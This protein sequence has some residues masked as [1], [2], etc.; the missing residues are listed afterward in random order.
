MFAGQR[1]ETFYIDLG[2]VFDTLNLRRYLP[3]LS[4]AEDVDNVN[5][6]GN[7]RFAKTNIN[8]IAIEVPIKCLIGDDKTRGATKSDQ[9]PGDRRLCE[10]EPAEDPGAPR[11]RQ[12]RRR[13]DRCVQVARMGNPL[14][15]ELIINTPQKDKWNATDPEDEAQFQDFYK[16]PV[17]ATALELVYGVPVVPFDDSPKE[18]RTDL[19]TVLL[20]YAGQSLN[21]DRCGQPC[22]ELLRLDMSKPPTAPEKQSRLGSVLGN[23]PAGWPNG[24]RPNDDVTDIAIR[25]VGGNNY[26]DDAGGRRGELPQGR[27][28]VPT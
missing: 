16:N 2:A 25:V 1:A 14:V 10:H 9:E 19:I 21:G 4:A 15:N 23:D 6:F 26:I 12:D 20:K 5:P 7:N 3:L 13:R 18:N 17:I 8:T 24:R 11:Q 28:A 22:A 27:S